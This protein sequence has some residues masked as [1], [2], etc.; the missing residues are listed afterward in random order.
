MTE[1][2]IDELLTILGRLEREK[3]EARPLPN[4]G[5]RKTLASGLV[6][7]TY[8]PLGPPNN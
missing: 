4:G 1:W 8:F 7:E 6:V 5:R 3:A 2:V